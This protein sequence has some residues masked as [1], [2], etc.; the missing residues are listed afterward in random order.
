MYHYFCAIDTGLRSK[1]LINDS[2]QLEHNYHKED[3]FCAEI[4]SNPIIIFLVYF[5]KV[6]KQK[7]EC[8]HSSIL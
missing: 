1:L 5:I 2:L 4:Q 3:S 7:Q 8:R 6:E